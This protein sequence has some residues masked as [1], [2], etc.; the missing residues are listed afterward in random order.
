MLALLGESRYQ[1]IAPLKFTAYE[2]YIDIEYRNPPRANCDPVCDGFEE[3]T[4]KIFMA[5]DDCIN[6]PAKCATFNYAKRACGVGEVWSRRPG[7]PHLKSATSIQLVNSLLE[8][9]CYGPDS[10]GCGLVVSMSLSEGVTT[11]ISLFSRAEFTEGSINDFI[12]FK[13]LN[14]RTIITIPG[15]TCEGDC[16]DVQSTRIM[17]VYTC[18]DCVPREYYDEGQCVSQPVETFPNFPDLQPGETDPVIEPNQRVYFFTQAIEWYSD[19]TNV[20]DCTGA[21][22]PEPRYNIGVSGTWI[23]ITSV[24]IGAQGQMPS[25][26]STSTSGTTRT[27]GSLNCIGVPSRTAYTDITST[28][29]RLVIGGVQF[30]NEMAFFM[31]KKSTAGSQFRAGV[32]VKEVRRYRF[33]MR[34][35]AG[36]VISEWEGPSFPGDQIPGPDNQQCASGQCSYFIN[37]NAVVNIGVTVGLLVRF[38]TPSGG[39]GSRTMPVRL[40]Q[41]ITIPI[42]RLGPYCG[43]QATIGVENTLADVVAGGLSIVIDRLV[44]A[45]IS[46]IIPVG[47]TIIS[48]LVD[49]G[50]SAN[51]EIAQCNA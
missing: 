17:P 27:T 44:D 33:Q 38:K 50:I 45:A 46:A 3:L 47:G 35:A 29:T 25:T 8:L 36:N 48:Q 28:T 18:P 42:A 13:E 30:T 4:F 6:P 43:N 31:S 41:G 9:C 7:A 24:E 11:L 20:N 2:N 19:V 39:T 5:L 40:G 23:P 37:V 15:I 49:V 21:V 10:E 51:T 22:V 34:D 14:N 1:I 32:R 16:V 26:G 12:L